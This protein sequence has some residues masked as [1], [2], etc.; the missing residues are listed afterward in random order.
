MCAEPTRA[1]WKYDRCEAGP[2]GRGLDGRT[3]KGGRRLHCFFFQA[4]DGIRDIGVTGVQTCAL[5]ISWVSEVE[6]YWLSSSQIT[7]SPLVWTRLEAEDGRPDSVLW[8]FRDRAVDPATTDPCA[9]TSLWTPGGDQPVT[10]C[11]ALGDGTWLRTSATWQE[12][13]RFGPEARVGVTAAP[14]VPREVLEEALG[15]ARPMTDAAYETWLDDGL[16][17]G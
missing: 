16:S 6:G 4:E 13:A 9:A 14:T 12:L 15:A 7:G 11:T 10:G 3:P 5:P 1:E 8:L 17:P 2:L